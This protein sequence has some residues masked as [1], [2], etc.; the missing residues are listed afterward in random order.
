MITTGNPRDVHKGRFRI[1][2]CAEVRPDALGKVDLKCGEQPGKNTDEYGG[3]QNVS[4]GILDFFGEDAHAIET[5][6]GSRCQ[7]RT[8]RDGANAEG[9]GIVERL[10]RDESMPLLVGE[11]VPQRLKDEGDHD[12]RHK[13]QKD[14]VSS[15]GGANSKPAQQSHG[16]HR[17][18]RQQGEGDVRQ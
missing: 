17:H 14:L 16:A 13:R 12:N 1:G 8:C 4:S 15:R 5:D 3:Q 2:E 10:G 11:D 18:S 6:I 9:L 7:G